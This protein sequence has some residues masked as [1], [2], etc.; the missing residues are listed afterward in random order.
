[1]GATEPSVRKSGNPVRDSAFLYYRTNPFQGRGAT[2][3]ISRQKPHRQTSVATSAIEGLKKGCGFENI[4]RLRYLRLDK[5][6][7]A[8]R[9][10]S[11]VFSGLAIYSGLT[12]LILIL[13]YQKIPPRISQTISKARLV[14][15]NYGSASIFT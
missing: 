2:L 14:E 3:L 15:A 7:F 6:S 5:L 10:G 11:L 1:M 4:N 8:R 12:L 13:I 9:H